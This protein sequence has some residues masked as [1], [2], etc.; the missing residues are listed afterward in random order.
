MGY[1][2]LTI[3]DMASEMLT[4]KRRRFHISGI[5]TGTSLFNGKA[6]HVLLFKIS[7]LTVHNSN[8]VVL[9]IVH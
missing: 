7:V 1:L 2:P 5:S 8:V 6:N 3:F 4:D 9:N